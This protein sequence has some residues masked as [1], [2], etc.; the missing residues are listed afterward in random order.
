MIPSCGRSMTRKICGRAPWRRRRNFF[1]EYDHGGLH[2]SPESA[3]AAKRGKIAGPL[4][5]NIAMLSLTDDFSGPHLEA[6]A[7]V[8][9]LCQYEDH[10]DLTTENIR[11]WTAPKESVD[12]I[13]F[14]RGSR[15]AALA[16]KRDRQIDRRGFAAADQSRSCAAIRTASARFELRE[17]R[18]HPRA[19]VPET[20]PPAKTFRR[21]SDAIDRRCANASCT[22]YANPRSR[23]KT[24][25]ATASG[26]C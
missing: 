1:R 24:R 6:D 21:P 9:R 18:S 26:M 22:P 25:G 2:Y 14:F 3:E 4:Q 17:R 23:R 20:T 5:L 16:E 10:I 15:I 12:K 11:M 13:H 19:N 8:E 7:A